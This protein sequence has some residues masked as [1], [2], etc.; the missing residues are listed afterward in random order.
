MLVKYKNE[1]YVI[2]KTLLAKV[3]Q[4]FKWDD[5]AIIKTIKGK[6]LEN[7]VYQHPLY[8]NKQCFVIL[9]DYVSNHD[10]TGLVHNAP[11]FGD[12]DYL[13]CKKYNINPTC[14]LDKYACFNDE[15]NDP[16]LKGLFYEKAND[17]IISRLKQ[18]NKILHH[19]EFTHS[20]PVD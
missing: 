7:V 16:E 3:V 12:D 9:A 14:P 20:A 11:S 2:G 15:L 19:S 13:A 10:G 18:Q 17:V 5:Y 1:Q 6:E 8:S 4:L